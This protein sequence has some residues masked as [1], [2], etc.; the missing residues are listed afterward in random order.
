[1]KGDV[2]IAFNQMVEEQMGIA[3]WEALLNDVKPSS[4]GVYTSVNRYDDSELSALIAALST[5]KSIPQAILIENFGFYLFSILNKK[6]AV[7]TEQKVDFFSFLA[8]IDGVIHRE[9]KKLFPDTQLP[10]I[11]CLTSSDTAMS[12]SYRSSRKLCLLAEGLI[13]GAAKHYQVNYV[14]DHKQCMHN[15]HEECLFD[16]RLQQ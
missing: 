8:S 15:G 12:L 3:C 9:V 10:E 16:L 5:M 2:F 13:R 14:L 4:G 6:Y 11:R 7:F 1:M